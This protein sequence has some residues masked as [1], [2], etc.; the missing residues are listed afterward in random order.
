MDREGLAVRRQSA[1]IQTPKGD[2]T[3]CSLNR[4]FFKHIPHFKD[5]SMFIRSTLIV[6]ACLTGLTAALGDVIK[7]GSFSA[8]SDGS[9]IYVRWISLD[10]TGVLRYELERKAGINGQFF[11]IAEFTTKGSNAA[12]DFV[13]DSAFRV[14]ETLYQY[15]IKI[16]FSNGSSDYAGPISV[17]HD[18]SEVW[19]TW[20]SIKAMFR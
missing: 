3:I 18:V 15:R 12:Y 17:R 2:L 14:V 6:V 1:G 19:R 9:N 20:G 7:D 13:D 10:E 4:I 8:R 5:P 16:V 11:L